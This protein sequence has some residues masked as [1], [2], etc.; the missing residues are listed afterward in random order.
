MNV[1]NISAESQRDNAIES[2]PNIGQ[3]LSRTREKLGLTQ[4]EVALFLHLTVSVIQALE[5][6]AFDKLPGATFTRGYL[7]LYGNLLKLSPDQI[8]EIIAQFNL[9]F[10]DSRES[11]P[12][13]YRQN[14][15]I[16]MKQK[17]G[18]E[19]YIKWISYLIFLGTVALVFV[20]WYNHSATEIIAK[21]EATITAFQNPIPVEHKQVTAVT[22]VDQTA[23]SP[24]P[25]APEN[26]AAVPVIGVGENSA[27]QMTVSHPMAAGVGNTLSNIPG[28][29]ANSGAL[30]DSATGNVSVSETIA[31]VAA[32]PGLSASAQVAQPLSASPASST[33]Q[34]K[35]KKTVKSPWRNPDQVE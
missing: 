12:V 26:S 31:N 20:W 29:Q 18:T 23:V 35:T 15:R 6:N 9:T 3:T 1:E 21:G 8:N 4:N 24:I 5:E 34:Q 22:G 25:A 32:V 11:V 28:L 2:M 16:Y 19:P 14:K 10:P 30:S 27:A 17:R 33:E 7:R 13:S